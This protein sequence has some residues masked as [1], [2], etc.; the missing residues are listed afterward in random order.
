MMSICC[1][2]GINGSQ[3]A[4]D[5]ARRVLHDRIYKE[6]EVHHGPLDAGIHLISKPFSFQELAARV[7]AR[8]DAPAGAPFESFIALGD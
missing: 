5:S 8:L 4:D 7:R 1:P 3:L 6:S 2:G